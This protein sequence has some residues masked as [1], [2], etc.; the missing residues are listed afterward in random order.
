MLVGD[1]VVGLQLVTILFVDGLRAGSDP[2][3]KDAGGISSVM[4]TRSKVCIQESRMYDEIT[5]LDW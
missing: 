1:T 5:R 4:M 2:R 3:E